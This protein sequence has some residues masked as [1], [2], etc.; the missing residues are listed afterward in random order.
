MSER[1]FS[2]IS[3]LSSIY[4]IKYFLLSSDT[5]IFL[6][7][8]SFSFS[9]PIFFR[10]F[11][12]YLLYFVYSIWFN[13][14]N[15]FCMSSWLKLFSLTNTLSCLLSPAVPNKLEQ[16]IVIRR[17]V[18]IKINLLFFFIFTPQ[19]LFINFSFNFYFYINQ[20]IIALIKIF[21]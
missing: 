2:W 20:S 4:S 16:F 12:N 13:S 8:D 21:V 5:S 9:F 1:L 3:F 11:F 17:H 6:S 7:S 10:P 18:I 15:I 14:V 19:Y